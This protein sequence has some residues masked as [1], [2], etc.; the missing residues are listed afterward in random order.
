MAVKRRGVAVLAETDVQEE[1]FLGNLTAPEV[2]TLRALGRRQRYP[3]GATLFVEGDR[4]DRV[5]V[6]TEGRVKISILTPDGKEVVLAVR[7]G[8]DLVGDQGFLDGA[9]RSATA[10]AMD[11]VDALL[12]PAGEFTLFLEQHARVALLLLKMLS[13][14]LRDADAKRAEFAAYDTVGR[15]ASRLVEMAGRFG[16]NEAAGIR[17]NLPLTQEEL[18]G[19]TG[20]SR[21]A[22]SKALGMLRSLG[23]IETH[24]RGITIV[25]IDGLR[26][27]A[28]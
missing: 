25:D 12:I 5:I 3:K 14:R 22:V 13:R 23:W 9:P 19:W 8:G 28:T 6:I 11:P 16:E 21:E 18:A 10:T 4:A 26:N 17:I 24:R 2:E 1:P 27:R 7:G 20:S 15:V